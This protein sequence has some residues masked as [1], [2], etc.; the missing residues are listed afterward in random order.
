MNLKIKVDDL[1]RV[2]GKTIFSGRLVSGS[3][4]PGTK[5]FLRIDGKNVAPIEIGGEVLNR[6]THQDFWTNQ[7][8]SVAR[9]DFLGRDVWLIQE[10]DS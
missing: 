8:V 10:G 3:A 2:G 7:D 1:F 6:S 9:S 4:V 5:C